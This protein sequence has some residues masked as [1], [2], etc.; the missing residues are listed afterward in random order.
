MH[1]CILGTRKLFESERKIRRKSL[2]KFSSLSLCE[3]ENFPII[4]SFHAKEY[5][6]IA[7]EIYGYLD[8]KSYEPDLADFNAILST[9]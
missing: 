8:I 6:G 4:V 9:L 2:L 7:E 3:L 1:L 5:N